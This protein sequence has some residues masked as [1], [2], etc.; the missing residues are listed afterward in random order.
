MLVTSSQISDTP[1]MSL[2]TGTTLA[3]T[4]D[5]IINPANLKIIAYELGGDNLDIKPSLLL[6]SDIREFGDMGMIVNS[7]EEFVSPD[8]IIKLKP[9][10]EQKFNP[11]GKHVKDTDHK[12][13]G[14]VIDYTIDPGSFIIQQLNVKRPLLQSLHEAE[15]LIHRSQ[16]V[17]INDHEIIIK[18]GKIKHSGRKATSYANPFR[19]KTPQAEAVKLKSDS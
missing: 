5:A 3:I 18:S 11:I 6:I 14:K 19:Q 12:K 13:V 1:V 8:D 2:Q 10:Y 9:L 16:I 17:E 7:S 4:K 15:R